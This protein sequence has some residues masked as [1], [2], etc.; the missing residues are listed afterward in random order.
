[1]TT[2]YPIPYDEIGR[3]YAV[4]RQSGASRARAQAELGLTPD[5]GRQLEVWFRRPR[6]GAGCDSV[7]PRFARHD[8]HVT[9]VLRG[10]G[11]PELAL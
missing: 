4:L 1:M 11:Y 6:P 2:T 7:R 10:G 9:A 5:R 3:T 8:A